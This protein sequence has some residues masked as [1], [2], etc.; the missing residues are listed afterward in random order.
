MSSLGETVIC[1]A[2]EPLDHR[3]VEDISVNTVP[4][5]HFHAPSGSLYSESL[6]S[7]Y[8]PIHEPVWN[9][10]SALL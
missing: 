4:S 5:N 7:W 10:M 9:E 8:K 1:W 3:Y 2:C 6:K